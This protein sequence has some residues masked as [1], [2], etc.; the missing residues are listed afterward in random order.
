MRSSG[1]EVGINTGPSPIDPAQRNH[2]H[3]RSHKTVCST[4]RSEKKHHNSQTST[5]PESSS[6]FS[7]LPSLWLASV[8]PQ[9]NTSSTRHQSSLPTT[10]PTDTH[11]LCLTTTG[12]V[13]T[14][15]SC[16]VDLHS[17]DI[18]LSNRYA[19]NK[20][21]QTS[22]LTMFKRFVNPFIYLVK[23]NVIYFEVL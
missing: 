11:S 16:V 20:N 22:H 19:L 21:I 8:P 5:C 17:P 1:A 15:T 2:Q 7:W 6:S 9:R 4:R 23:K 18:L 12:S 13:L 14:R 3:T 10:T